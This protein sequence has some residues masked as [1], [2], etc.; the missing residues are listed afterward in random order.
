MARNGRYVLVVPSLDPSLHLLRHFGRAFT[1]VQDMSSK[2]GLQRAFWTQNSPRMLPE[3]L[4]IGSKL[5]PCP[6]LLCW[7]GVRSVGPQWYTEVPDKGSIPR[8]HGLD[9]RLS[10][11]L[12]GLPPLALVAAGVARS[13]PNRTAGSGRDEVTEVK[14][15]LEGFQGWAEDCRGG[16]KLLFLQGFSR[17]KFLATALNLQLQFRPRRWQQCCWWRH[18]VPYYVFF[19]CQ[20]GFSVHVSASIGT[21]IRT[22]QQQQQ[23]QQQQ[24]RRQQQRQRQRQRQRQQQQSE[25]SKQGAQR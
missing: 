6:F 25:Q 13:C 8:A 18:V 24:Q 23:Q 5:G 12:R 19:L 22:R 16:W 1:C 17:A 2:Q 20:P 14:A 4:V 21:S 11:G 15:V 3:R 10:T 9:Y 7:G